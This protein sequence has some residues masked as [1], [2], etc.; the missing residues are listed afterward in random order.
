MDE[1]AQAVLMGR[2]DGTTAPPAPVTTPALA[3]APTT[4]PVPTDAPISTTPP[5]PASPAAPVAGQA[6][7]ATP[8]TPATPIAP[9]PVKGQAEIVVS[10]EQ[11]LANIGLDEAPDKK[12]GRVE[13]EYAASSKESRR[14][15]E[16]VKRLRETLDEQGLVVTEDEQKLPAGLFAT[17]KYNKDVGELAVKFKDL[18]E[19]AQVLFESEPQKAIDMI[20]DKARK[21]LVRVMPTTDQLPVTA[22]TPERR[23]SALAY[24]SDSKW[25][26]GDVRF[27]GMTANQKLI[28]QMIDSPTTSKALK[29]FYNQEPEIALSLLHL[30]LEH[31]RSHIREQIKKSTEAVDVKKKAADA[32]PTLDPS[33][34]GVPTLGEAGGGSY[35]EQ[36]AAQIGKTRLNP[37]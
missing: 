26:T 33:G 20:V 24:L 30:Q 37:Y 9:A 21:A 31:A 18:P 34:G 27:P 32:I 7:A 29:D 11:L 13:R 28:D 19:D 25:E 22:I 35:A 23:E 10:D 14:L 17:K 15:S 5:T 3:P 4:V 2:S 36:L 1:N 16:Y 12:L 6:A 8:G